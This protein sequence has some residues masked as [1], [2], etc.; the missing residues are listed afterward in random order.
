M[1]STIAGLSTVSLLVYFGS[2]AACGGAT[3]S[4]DDAGDDAGAG[5]QGDSGRQGD[6]G[7]LGDGGNTLGAECP[8]SAPAIGASC[9]TAGLTCE[10]GGAGSHLRC[11]TIFHCDPQGSGAS[12]WTGFPPS[13]DCVG[14]QAENA[15]A[16]PASFSALA[17]G[18][19]CP[20]APP[21]GGTCVYA[22]GLCGCAPC[23]KADGGGADNLWSCKTWPAPP[24]PCPSPRPRAGSACTMEGESCSY[25]AVCTSVSFDQP[26]L[27]CVSGLWHDEPVAQ[28]P[29]VFPS[30][31][32]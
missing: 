5:G 13:A 21:G 32:Q 14:T 31:G 22:D 16:C 30:C 12:T 10:Y 4:V 15:V 9:A 11:S 20:L 1:R 7:R 2:A 19:T 3:A 29:C 24:A 25:G 17:S 28:P 27:K 26:D 23:A 8:A 18:S 6:G